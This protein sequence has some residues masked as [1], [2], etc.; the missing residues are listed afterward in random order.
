MGWLFLLLGVMAEATS[1]VALR[2]TNGFTNWLPS[3]IV[4]L[5]HLIAF[6]FL[7]Q[8]MK[9]LPVGIVHTIWTGLAIVVVTAMSGLIYK[10]H[11]DA[12]VWLGMIVV[13]AGIAI[14]NLAGAPHSH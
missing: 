1:H 2:A 8:A 7:G 6:I 14:I 13:A 9:S 3:T 5:G 10:Q 4:I 11:L 12:K